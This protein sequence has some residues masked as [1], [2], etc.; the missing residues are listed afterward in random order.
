[1]SLD[2]CLYFVPCYI[3]VSSGVVRF[4]FI[5]CPLLYPQFLRCCYIFVYILSH[6][7]PR[8]RQVSSGNWL[9]LVISAIPQVSSDFYLYLSHVIPAFPSGVVRVL[10]IFCP[11]LY[12]G[13][14]GYRQVT[15]CPLLYQRF[16]RCRQISIY[17]LSFVIQRFL[18]CRQV[19]VYI[20]SLVIPR[21]VG[22]PQLIQVSVYNLLS[23]LSSPLLYKRFCRESPTSFL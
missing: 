16:L 21:F 19:S 3:S 18:R 15:G 13:F 9:S 2:F 7:I 8:V 5:F 10:F 1:M 14:A 23:L 22:C 4:L 11:M 6:F 20:L 12:Q 17:I